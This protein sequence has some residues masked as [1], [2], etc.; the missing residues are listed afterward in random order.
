MEA[1]GLRSGRDF[2]S[3]GGVGA[4]VA[5]GFVGPV[6]G[7]PSEAGDVAIFC[8]RTI[9]ELRGVWRYTAEILRQA[10]ILIVGSAAVICFMQFVMGTI[11]GTNAA[12]VLRTYG[13]AAY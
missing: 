10:G 5:E 9:V 12:Y 6:R 8:G 3:G 4:Q 13:A 2:G 7:I 1:S 11:C